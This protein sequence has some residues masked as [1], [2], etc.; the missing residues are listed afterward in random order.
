MKEYFDKESAIICDLDGTV[1]LMKGKRTPYEYAKC[2]NDAPNSIV[3]ESLVALSKA[4]NCQIIFVTARENLMLQDDLT[5]YLTIGGERIVAGT[6]SEQED[7]NFKLD[8]IYDLT[9]LWLMKHIPIPK[10]DIHLFIRGEGNH[11]KDNYVKLDIYQKWIKPHWN[12]KLVLD[13]RDQVVE[14][15]RHGAKLP[16]F[17]VADGNF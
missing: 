11:D 1:A 12:V 13:D 3:I 8:S 4:F 17:Q 5:M 14:M 9:L 6:N 15:W 2:F 16:C 10:E 7:V